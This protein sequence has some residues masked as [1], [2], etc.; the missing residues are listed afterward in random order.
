MYLYNY[1]FCLDLVKQNTNDI[2]ADYFSV[3]VCF[4]VT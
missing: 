1:L 3:K 2:F 4:L